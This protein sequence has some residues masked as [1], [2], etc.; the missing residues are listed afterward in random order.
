VTGP[1]K[2]EPDSATLLSG[3]LF[4]GT[5]NKMR[6]LALMVSLCACEARLTIQE[7]P[8][9]GDAAE[10][11]S[12]VAPPDTAPMCQNGRKVF[13]NFDGVIL[14]DGLKSDAKNNIASWMTNGVTTAT[15]PPY[16]QGDA[17]RAALITGITQDVTN[18]LAAFPTEV[19][20]V[21]PA[22]G[23]Y[24][25]VVFGGTTGNVGSNFIGVQ[26]LDC[27]DQTR[28]D[29]AW[30]A[31]NLNTNFVVNVVRGSIGFGIGMTAVN[32]QTDCMCSWTNGCQ[33]LNSQCTL[34]DG[35]VRDPA[36]VQ[37]CP[38]LAGTIQDEAIAVNAAFCN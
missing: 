11:D 25:M 19:V 1:E 26:E 18:R 15:V 12:P 17:G 34:H 16:R 31:D 7:S 21:R 13:L 33:Y 3:R 10:G 27:G 14:N 22:T 4:H 29:V 8:E 24:M 30:I 38:G 9:L 5:M 6:A 28:N 32:D 20:T 23:D 35:V 2:P 36:A 37:Q